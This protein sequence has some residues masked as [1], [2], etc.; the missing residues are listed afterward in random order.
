M[1]DYGFG[2]PITELS[3]NR[4]GLARIRNGTD[5]GSPGTKVVSFLFCL[6]FAEPPQWLACTTDIWRISV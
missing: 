4:R 2:A 5:G 3:A 6:T 1:G